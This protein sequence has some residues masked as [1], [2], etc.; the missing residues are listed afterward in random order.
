MANEGLPKMAKI[1]QLYL[2]HGGSQAE[3]VD[4]IM[5]LMT[6]A[7]CHDLIAYNE[8]T[9]KSYFNGRSSINR[10][11]RRVAGH[12]RAER[13]AQYIDELDY[14]ARSRIAKN[15]A[16]VGIKT[17]PAKAGDAYARKLEKIINDA[18]QGKGN[19]KK[20]PP[21]QK[22]QR[23]ADRVSERGLIDKYVSY[24]NYE[25]LII[26]NR[27]FS[28]DGSRVFGENTD[29]RLSSII[30]DKHGFLSTELKHYPVIFAIWK[31][32]EYDPETYAKYHG[33]DQN[34]NISENFFTIVKHAPK[35]FWTLGI[36]EFF[37]WTG[38][39]YLWTYGAG[40]V[41]QNIWH[42][43]NVSSAAYQAAGNWFGVLSAVEVG[44][45]I[46]YGLVLQK[47]NDR[48]RKPAYALGM[49]L[50]ALGFW[51]LSV[52][53]TKLL[54]FV[55]FIGIGMCWVTINSIP[56]TILTNALDGKHD[57]TYMGL[58][59]CWICLPQIV[60]SVC[61]FALY[62]LLGNYIPHMLVVSAVLAL[63]GAF[64]VYVV[65]ETSVEKGDIE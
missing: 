3:C 7:K 32:D 2:G 54:S 19:A 62:P 8:N 49:V 26:D 10:L 48:I 51:G 47:L 24:Q 44:V 33:L 18:A 13:M 63:I 28:H 21:L 58:F 22:Q 15:L 5:E 35:V 56:F 60:A 23:L 42:T 12:L 59:N 14:Q 17:H 39:Q 57:G 41:A 55:A 29:H 40:T 64:T 16:Q 1:L 31:V 61:S 11:A 53:P 4:K 46:I 45:A 38:F 37:S 25:L 36:V 20:K 43:T 52:A 6:D 34:A 30:W 50:G 27:D 65:K 9:F